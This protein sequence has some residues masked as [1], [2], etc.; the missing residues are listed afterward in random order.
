MVGAGLRGVR[1]V[2]VSAPPCIS[3]MPWRRVVK[4]LRVMHGVSGDQWRRR[5]SVKMEDVTRLW[6]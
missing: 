2:A 3:L 4:F 5:R 6:N 1:G